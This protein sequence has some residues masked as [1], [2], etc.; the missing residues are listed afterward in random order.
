MFHFAI[1]LLRTKTDGAPAT[2]C[3]GYLSNTFVK[4]VAGYDG[5]HRVSVF[6]MKI[7]V[8]EIRHFGGRPMQ[9]LF[10]LDGCQ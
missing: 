6:T 7:S 10:F 8:F 3:S 1:F 5:A 9:Q 4:E 2:T